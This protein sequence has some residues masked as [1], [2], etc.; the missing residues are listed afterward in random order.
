MPPAFLVGEE[1]T[2][3]AGACCAAQ[4][5]EEVEVQGQGRLGRT[6]I[7]RWFRR[8]REFGFDGDEPEQIGRVTGRIPYLIQLFDQCLQAALE[9]DGGVHVGPEEFARA[10]AKFNKRLPEWL[11]RLASGSDAVRLTA[12]EVE[13]LL[14]VAVAA[15]STHFKQP[16]LLQDLGADWD[17]RLYEEPWQQHIPARPY[18][19]GW[20][21][22]LDDRL[23][24]KVVTDLGLLPH[25]LDQPPTDTAFT[26]EDPLMRYIVPALVKA[27][28]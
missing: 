6:A 10:S 17:G 24:A 23:A 12:R 18:P 8:T 22:G 2:F 14:M 26:Q 28:G 16:V 9:A 25:P 27:G 21:D 5:G 4:A 15:Q 20:S 19:K 1:W 13:L 11:A 7:E 3:S